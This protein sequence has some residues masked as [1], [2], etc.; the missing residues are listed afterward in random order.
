[1]ASP[2]ELLRK[3]SLPFI[4]Q[5]IE[6]SS[7]IAV[8]AKPSKD[9]LFRA[10]FRL[11]PSQRLQTDISCEFVLL[12]SSAGHGVWTGKLA[13]S[14]DF[15]TF[16][17]TDRHSCSF[18]IPLFCVRKVERVNSPAYAFALSITL[19]HGLK[20]ALQFIALRHHCDQFCNVLKAG[21]REHV[22]KEYG[23]GLHE[24]LETCFSN[25][26]VER[27]QRRREGLIDDPSLLRKTPPA[28]LGR[29]YRYPGDPIK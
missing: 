17:S 19:W 25:Y 22:S 6:P 12:A 24:F 29:Y 4:N 14:T 9:D 27:L 5:L 28:G 20:L 13:I 23:K 1:M 26:L 3:A 7:P 18:A 16:T 15:L 8:D 21:L 11:P 10:Q 2:L